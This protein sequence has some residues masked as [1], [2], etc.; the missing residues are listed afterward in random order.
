MSGIFSKLITQEAEKQQQTIKKA[1]TQPDPDRSSD[2]T[3]SRIDATASQQDAKKPTTIIVDK[4]SL[5]SALMSTIINELSDARTLS[6]AISVRMTQEEKAHI[7]DFILDTLRR[8]K[9]QGQEV[10]MAKLM[11]YALVYILLKHQKEFVEVL[12]TTLTRDETGKL[13][14]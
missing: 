6:S 13:F 12:K 9:L 14:Q 2:A 7:D 10:S 8:E 5:D 4:F 1:K 3:A 11:R